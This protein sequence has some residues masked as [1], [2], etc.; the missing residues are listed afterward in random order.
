[1][2][3]KERADAYMAG[4]LSYEDQ[5]KWLSTRSLLVML[6]RL[7]IRLPRLTL[8]QITDFLEQVDSN[9]E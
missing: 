5:M 6:K 2:S 3:L 7:R 1:M 4:I 9:N 8:G